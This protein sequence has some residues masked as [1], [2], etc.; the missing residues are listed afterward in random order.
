MNKYTDKIRT[1]IEKIIAYLNR[2]RLSAKNQALYARR[3]SILLRSGI[4]IVESF[5][6][7]KKQCSKNER[8]IFDLII[9]D[10]SNG[11]TLSNSMSKQKGIFNDTTIN[12]V[13]VGEITG[14]LDE[15]LQYLSNEI[16]K[17]INLKTKIIGAL[18]YPA[19][20]IIGALGMT[21]FL[22][23]YLFPKLTPVFKSLHVKLPLST[24]IL[25]FVSESLTRYWPIFLVTT[26]LA[27]MLLIVFRKKP[28]LR[29][30]SEILIFKIPVVGNMLQHYHLS[31]ICRTLGILL[32]GSLRIIEA[33]E[34]TVETT[35]SLMYKNEF[36]RLIVTTK[37]GSTISDQFNKNVSLFP[38]VLVGMI[39]V[40]EKTGTLPDSLVFLSKM[41]EQELDET[42]KKLTSLMEPAI[43]ISL[44][45]IVGFVAI[46]IITP[47]Y[48]VT[49]NI[50]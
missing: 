25:I 41:Y 28:R 45:V 44:G 50:H 5:D 19:V 2:P 46:S 27:L 23:L 18:L 39:T 24:R 7:L 17:N 6:L 47:I 43:M 10:I 22:T 8:K 15:N 31:N 29:T 30:Y 38:P 4:P 37:N 42:T 33:I 35:G 1:I 32:K 40:G 21:G 3:L 20:V 36:K 12:L 16:E 48:E 14:N 11:E 9:L 34:I 49:Q 26:I 13:K